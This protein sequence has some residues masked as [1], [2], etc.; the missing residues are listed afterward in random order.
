MTDINDRFQVLHE[1]VTAAEARLE[2]EHWDYLVGGTE[3]ETTQRRNR[4]ALDR[5]AFRPRV[6]RDVSKIDLSHQFFGQPIS[7]PITVAPVGAPET[8]DPRGAAAVMEAA[9][10]AGV[11]S[12]HSS[13]TKQ[14]FSRPGGAAAGFTVFQLYVRGDGDWVDAQVAEAESAGFDA[15]C[16]T[17]DTAIYS[18]R[19]RDIAKRF[20][21]PWRKAATG[22]EH[23]ASFNWRDVERFKA[24][25]HIPLILKGIATVEDARL[26]VDAGVEG[27][28]ISNHGGRQLDHGL[29]SI[30]LLP[31]IVAAVSGRATIIIDGGFMRGTD[32]VKAM[33]LGADLVGLGRLPMLALAAAGSPGLVRAFDL[34]RSEMVSALGLLGVTNWSELDSSYVTA[35]EPVREAQPLSAFPLLE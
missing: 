25:H 16:I 12:F 31:E 8:F 3:T 4:L 35:G 17:V 10:E 13:V 11:V 5:L 28:Y 30:Q 9:A 27:I 6:L 24:R 18:R 20:L 29:G 14:T 1:F 19:E 34:L 21:K 23:Q 26:A 15:F 7:L 32:I 33:A 22:I 2:P